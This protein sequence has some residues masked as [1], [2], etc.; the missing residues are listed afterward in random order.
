MAHQLHDE[1]STTGIDQVRSNIERIISSYRHT[2]D[3]YA[4]LIQNS[5]DAI[6]EKFDR[7]RL[8]EGQV[9][10]EIWPA[11]RKIAILDNG[12][13]I[14][15][16]DLSS[17]LV[18]GKS[19]KRERGHASYGFMG[20]GLTFVA[21]QT[22]V[23]K[24]ESVHDGQRASRTY[25]NLH[26]FVYAGDPLPQSKE[27]ALAL[28]GAST[29]ETSWTRVTATFP[30]CFPN[31]TLEEMLRRT[32]EQTDNGKAFSALLRTRT[33][34]GLLDPVFGGGANFGFRLS[35][36]DQ[37]IAVESA[38]L[39]TR[40]MIQQLLPTE[41][42]LY[43]LTG[44]FGQ[45]VT[46][47]SSLPA[48]QQDTARQCVLL[49]HVVPDLQIGTTATPLHARLYI[50]CTSKDL[51]N[52]YNE[53]LLG[54]PPDGEAFRIEN[55]LWLAL[56]GMPTGICLDAYSHP[57]FLPFSAIIDVRDQ[58]INRE[59]DA[60]RK[61]ISEYRVNQIRDKVATI[62]REQGF[63]KYRKYVIGADTRLSNPLYDP[64]QELQKKFAGKTRYPIVLVQPHLPPAEEQGVITLFVEL[65]ARGILLG[66]EQKVISG[67]EV[68]DGLYTYDLSPTA[69]SLLSPS[70][71]LGIAQ[72]VF[73]QNRLHLQKDV[74]IEFKIDL[75]SVYRDI[76]KNRKDISQMDILVCWSTGPQDSQYY[77]NTHGDLL[78]RK[79]D[80]TNV[81]YGVTHELVTGKRQQ[82]LPI[83][84]LKHVLSTKFNMQCG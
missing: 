53:Q 68:Y 23:I 46:A 34:V 51:L 44:R 47:T 64:K 36:A 37:S 11:E 70:N 40:G 57:S 50:A 38:Y 75:G 24:I 5:A 10:L 62:L 69:G 80:T 35:I 30:A 77:Q 2:S 31:P 72:S 48:R 71:P 56:N 7:S 4:E 61:G 16:H 59:L 84:E 60:G 52:K 21:F 43:D 41:T 63:I 19:L 54:L 18:N 15:E 66:Y 28:T 76:E 74:L 45:L 78:Q 17:V 14:R 13:G 32:F 55:G 83:I 39:T 79:A 73:D 9:A 33:A 3:I 49:D 82:A 1:L 65:L 29:H 6:A 20:F 67:Y 81:F 58:R 42:R 26:R 12:I 22:S 25:E 8:T 27:E